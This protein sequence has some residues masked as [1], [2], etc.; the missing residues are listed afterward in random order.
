MR[1]ERGIFTVKSCYRALL[2]DLPS[3]NKK[4]WAA[5]WKMNVP[6]K[7]KSFMWHACANYLPTTDLLRTK[8]VNC[9]T[10][11]PLCRNCDESIL[12]LLALCPTAMQVWNY[13]NI[14]ISSSGAETIGDWLVFNCNRLDKFQGNLMVMICW[15]IWYARNERVWNNL[16]VSPRTIVE[17]AKAHLTEWTTVQEKDDFMPSQ[18]NDFTTRWMKPSSGRLKLN[19]DAAVDHTRGRMGF[20]WVLRNEHGDFIAAVSLPWPGMYSVKEAEAIAVREALSWL[21]D[22]SISHCQ[23]ETDALQITQSLQ[24]TSLDSQFDLILLDVKDLLS[25]LQDVFIS[26]A[27]RSTNRIAHLLARGSL[28]MSDRRIWDVCP[29]SFI[30]T[31][32]SAD[33]S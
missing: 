27:K 13:S 28:S 4:K 22:K 14:P 25:S 9:S 6:P 24:S 29:P 26:F 19:V 23:V 20:G 17:K 21:K 12:H 8:K 30:V 2:G 33:L 18:Q 5:L 31:L 7:V 16:V 1:E 15:Y 10:Y 11:C 32:L 3:N